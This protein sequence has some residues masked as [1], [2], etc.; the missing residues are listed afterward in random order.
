MARTFRF[1]GG[2]LSVD[3]LESAEA[4]GDFGLHV[5]PSGIVLAG[6]VFTHLRGALAAACAA[7]QPLL[8]VELGCGCSVVGI[9]A[10]KLGA[11]ALLT[12]AVSQP[13]V[14]ALCTQNC[15]LNGVCD[16]VQVAALDWGDLS[17]PVL[18][19]LAPGS[20][21]FI[22]GADILYDAPRA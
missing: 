14:L 3:I 7:G 10:A 18:T 9:V 13:A 5:W 20:V 21:A 2:A 15:A 16:S 6:Y 19:S 22:F 1:G 11:R 12:D 8:C 4:G 17:S